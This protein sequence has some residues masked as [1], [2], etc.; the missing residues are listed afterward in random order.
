MPPPPPCHVPS[1]SRALRAAGG[2]AAPAP[3][4]WCARLDGWPDADTLARAMT[5]AFAAF[6]AA[7]GRDTSA[8]AEREARELAGLAAYLRAALDGATV[9][10]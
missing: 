10:R 6:D 3:A 9:Q 1:R 8:P 4:C 5:R 7:T 2:T